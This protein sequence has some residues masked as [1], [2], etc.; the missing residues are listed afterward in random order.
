MKIF[1]I[2]SGDQSPLLV[3]TTC[4][5]RSGVSFKQWRL[6]SN[7]FSL[8]I[9]NALPQILNVLSGEMAL[10]GPRPVTP[11]VQ[12]SLEQRDPAFHLRLRLQ[13]GMTGWGRLSGAA[14]QEVDALRWELQRDLYYLRHFSLD[15]DLFILFRAMIQ[16]C[17]ILAGGI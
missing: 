3:G 1:Q 6:A 9:L 4:L 12:G 14:S 8:S 16:Q 13:P 11:S 2:F 17:L 7:P 15:L 5:G 10:V